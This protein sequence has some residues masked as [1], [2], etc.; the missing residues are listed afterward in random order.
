MPRIKISHRNK[1][2]SSKKAFERYARDLIYE[3]IGICESVKNTEY[4]DELIE[5]LKRHHEFE[6]KSK[7]M[8]DLTIRKNSVGNGLEIHF[9][10]KYNNYTDISWRTAIKGKARSVQ[11]NFTNALR[12]T[13]FNQIMDFKK[14]NINV[15][16]LCHSSEEVEYHA[17][18][19]IHFEKLVFDFLDKNKLPVPKTFGD[20]TDGRNRTIFLKQD[21]QF[22]LSWENYHKDNAVLRIL[23]KDCNLSRENYSN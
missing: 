19:K 13:I 21:E 15:C 3:K 17:D 1:I 12:E 2:Y 23:C 4:Y 16:E 11:Q 20:T 22:K 18:H 10:D 14:N 6:D 8:I 5:L 7:N 9:V